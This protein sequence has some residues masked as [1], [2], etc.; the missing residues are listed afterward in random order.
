M[1]R[2]GEF[3]AF[4]GIAALLH[5]AFFAI[6]PRSG[7]QSSGAGGNAM[8]TLQA[9]D[10]T[11]ADL[12][13]TWQRPVQTRPQ[14]D[15]RLEDPTAATLAPT[16]PQFELATAPRAAIETRLREPEVD[17]TL[18]VDTS[19]APPPPEPEPE[20]APEPKP[21]PEPV[22][23]P[24]P[25]P[26]PV[27]E[28]QPA[29][30]PTPAKPA[31]PAPK[32][33]PAPADARKAEQNSAGVAGQRAAGSGASAQAGR[34]G[35][36]D[37][38]TGNAGQSAKLK[39]IWGA[40][41][42]ARIERRKRYPAGARGQGR[43]VVQLVVSRTGQLISHRVTKSSGTPAFDKAALQ[44]ITRAGKFPSAPKKLQV[45]QMTFNLQMTFSK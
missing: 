25:E 36:S 14:L 27:P 24:A 1:K 19:T 2:T 22:P 10:P 21:E 3:I 9:A 7:S 39:S 30:E 42:R 29:P 13:E 5:V 15:T 17:E 11:I 31:K 8:V 35:G 16:V 38:A 37:V 43:V 32:P 45:S 33:E 4:G 28:P 26:E 44:A 6:A 12:V 20:P 34:S 23:D 41:I 40:K 18:A